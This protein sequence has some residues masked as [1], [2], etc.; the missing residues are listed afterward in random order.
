VVDS[1]ILM[2]PH[3]TIALRAL[4]FWLVFNVEPSAQTLRRFLDQEPPFDEIDLM[5]FSHGTEGIGVASIDQWRELVSKGGKGHFL[6]VDE[7]LYPRDFATLI[8]YHRD[9]SRLGPVEGMP[10]P[11]PPDRFEALAARYGPR[12]GIMVEELDSSRKT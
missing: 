4:P 12:L 2:D 5:L 9:L 3:R 11:L 6:G 8:R 1:F 7:D 10:S